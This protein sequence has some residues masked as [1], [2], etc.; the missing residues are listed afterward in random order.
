MAVYHLGGALQGGLNSACEI[1]DLSNFGFGD[2]TSV[3]TR[4][5][6]SRPVNMEH[7]AGRLRIVSSEHAFEDVHNELH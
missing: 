4:Y 7:D 3:D 2:F 5:T 1:E 6:D